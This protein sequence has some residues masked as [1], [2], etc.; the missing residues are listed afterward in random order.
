LN[1]GPVILVSYTS[2]STLTLAHEI[3]HALKLEHPGATLDALNLMQDLLDDGPLGADAR[4]RLTV[5]QAFIMNV[6]NE[7]WMAT[8]DPG[9]TRLC[10][11]T[12]PCPPAV[13]DA[14]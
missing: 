13:L 14:R 3:A 12:D 8:A 7:S 11:S 10:W 9:P 4:S 5:G 1:Q 6:E 2:Q